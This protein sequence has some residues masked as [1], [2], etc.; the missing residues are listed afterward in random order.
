M[1]TKF[2]SMLTK[3]SG[4]I[5]LTA[6]LAFAAA[7]ASAK[8]IVVN[9][10]G[11]GMPGVPYAV[12]LA[13]GYYEELGVDVTGVI[14]GAGGGA[15]IRNII[16]NTEPTGIP[17]GE[18]SASAYLA[19]K[20]SGLPIIAIHTAVYPVDNAWVVMPDSDIKGIEDIKGKRIGYTSPKAVSDG[21][22]LMA[23]DGLGIKHDEVERIPGGGVGQNLAMLENGGVDIGYIVEP[24]ASVR[25]DRYREILKL[26]DHVDAVPL[27][28][29]GVVSEEFAAA[30]PDLIASLI[31]ARVKAV[32]FIYENPAEA[33][34]I[35]AKAYDN[36]PEEI[37]VKAVERLAGLGYWT[38]GE[39][40][41]EALLA[42]EESLRVVGELDNP[43]DWP[44]MIDT[45]F[46]PED[47]RAATDVPA[48]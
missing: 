27:A 17:Y 43:V 26:K 21:F 15:V 19:A 12:A 9:L 22:S 31:A 10:W 13:N 28:S 25:A 34:R 4:A 48:E 46:M 11:I 37:A 47:L 38:R 24:L 40:K 14:G 7:S 44:A 1:Y 35:V 23:L 18:A 6:T 8:D 42:F 29:F 2:S 45:S 32:D 16:A 20:Q 41:M 33:G 36:L 39:I 30:N 3:S 5:V